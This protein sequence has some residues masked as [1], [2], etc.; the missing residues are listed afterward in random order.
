MHLINIWFL[1]ESSICSI[2]QYSSFEYFQKICF[3]WNNIRKI[4]TQDPCKF[5][6]QYFMIYIYT[7]V[8][9]QLI[10]LNLTCV[11]EMF[12]VHC[13]YFLWSHFLMIPWSY[14][15]P[16][17]C[18]HLLAWTLFSRC[19]KLS[20][21]IVQSNLHMLNIWAKKKVRHIQVFNLIMSFLLV[22]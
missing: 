13:G 9:F 16:L 10:I 6:T 11:W 8:L 1:R 12:S 18:E 3:H 5:S 15:N 17:K 22:L 4:V 2:G 20:G 19:W 14:K 7:F 21:F